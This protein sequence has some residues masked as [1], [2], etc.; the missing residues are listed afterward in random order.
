[1]NA[2]MI[3]VFVVAAL[4][5]LAVAAYYRRS[6]GFAL[7][8]N[9]P[10]EI[11][12][13]SFWCKDEN[14]RLLEGH[15]CRCAA[16][17]NGVKIWEKRGKDARWIYFSKGVWRMTKYMP[18]DDDCDHFL[19]QSPETSCPIGVWSTPSGEITIAATG[20]LIKGIFQ[21]GE[22]I[23][24]NV[25][26]SPT[27]KKGT[28]GRVCG[29]ADGSPHHLSVIFGNNIHHEKIALSTDCI[30]RLEGPKVTILCND[31]V[32]REG[33]ICT[34]KRYRLK[35][36]YLSDS[37]WLPT[38]S[39]RLIRGTTCPSVRET[40]LVNE[41]QRTSKTD[42][43]LK[44]NEQGL[45]LSDAGPFVRMAFRV[46]SKSTGKIGTY[47]RNELLVVQ[48][49][50]SQW[51]KELIKKEKTSDIPS[52]ISKKAVKDAADHRVKIAMGRLE[53]SHYIISSDG[54]GDDSESLLEVETSET[55]QTSDP[56]PTTNPT[57]SFSSSIGPP[58]FTLSCNNS[59]ISEVSSLT[60]SGTSPPTQ[61]SCTL[62]L[63]RS[64]CRLR[65]RQQLQESN[66][67]PIP[68][69]EYE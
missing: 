4:L 68:V 5:A 18:T 62:E 12:F 1:M 40:V 13:A 59:T 66:L 67:L 57:G 45:V 27:I 58:T 6:K 64:S 48:V 36:R 53:Q 41:T 26:I 69:A 55:Q 49:E 37:E 38:D 23:E 17:V 39:P 7:K 19:L 9:Q 63:R 61:T 50:S 24:C 22:V 46:K 20:S 56:I 28:A 52:P 65:K 31:L 32:W 10:E 11:W 29:M 42:P 60:S 3:F 2:V 33:Y 44:T 16:E 8:K 14:I 51:A 25:N 43:I 21:V 34:V 54:S 15:F 35:V 30:D 47:T